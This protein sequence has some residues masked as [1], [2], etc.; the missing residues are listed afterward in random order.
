MLMLLTVLLLLALVA[1]NAWVWLNW[2]LV[3]PLVA[4][5]LC[6]LGLYLVQVSH[7][8][9]V[10]SRSRRQVAQMFSSYVPPALVEVMARNPQAYSMA[11]TEKELTVLFI[12]IREFSSIAERLSP[13][14]L[15]EWINIYLSTVSQVICND[16]NGT[17]DKYMG[18]A[19]MAFW[20]APVADDAHAEHAVDAAMQIRYE[21]EQLNYQFRRRGWP[22][23]GISMGINTG[24]MRVGDMGSGIRRAYTVMGDAVNIAAQLQTLTREYGA[25]VLMGKDTAQALSVWA[26]RPV[27]SVRFIGRRQAIELYE[28]VGKK[29]QLSPQWVDELALWQQVLEHY[30]AEHWAQAIEGLNTLLRNN[31]GCYLY[32]LYKKRVTEF[33][34]HPG[35]LRWDRSFY[36]APRKIQ[37]FLRL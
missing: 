35:L 26:T 16:H 25:D 31:P 7:G 10:E 2:H 12:N 14:E 15:A 18:D 29:A 22:A 1:G 20:G 37:N 8:Y 3:L 36:M 28:P 6:V 9:V 27:D 32:A 4:P 34:D 33:R 19:V 30:R 24:R 21:V 23:I 13:S 17:L 5:V 11:A